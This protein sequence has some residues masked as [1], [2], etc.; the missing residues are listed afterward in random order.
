MAVI[1]L[2]K[3]AGFGFVVLNVEN[4]ILSSCITLDKRGTHCLLS[5]SGAA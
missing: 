5:T 3:M 2:T 1:F 4:P